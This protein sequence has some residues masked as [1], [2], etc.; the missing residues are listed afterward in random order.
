MEEKTLDKA[1]LLVDLKAL[2][3]Q[4]KI[5]VKTAAAII[6]IGRAT[7]SRIEHGD[8]PSLM[9]ALKIAASYQIP[10]EQIWGVAE[11]KDSEKPATD[12]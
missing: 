8:I 12:Q 10:V 4:T 6:G 7:L 1:V 11:E 5:V 9:I 2:R 3:E